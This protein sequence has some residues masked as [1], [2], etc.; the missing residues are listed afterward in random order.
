MQTV[1][2][3]APVSHICV[4]MQSK[5]GLH[6]RA[7][8]SAGSNRKR[9]FFHKSRLQLLEKGCKKPGFRNVCRLLAR[10]SS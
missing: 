2:L 4:H 3:R 7:S 6:V 9:R 5:L 1:M 10:T 8:D